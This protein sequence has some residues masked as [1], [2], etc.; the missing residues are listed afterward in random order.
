MSA[1][2]RLSREIQRISDLS[3]AGIYYTQ[4]P[5]LITRGTAMIIGPQDSIYANCPLFFRFDFPDDYP[6]QPPKVLFLTSDGKT[7]FHPN[8]YT[9]G[10]VCLSILGT[11]SGPSWQSTMSFSMILLSLKAL[12]DKNPLRHEPG[13][14]NVSLNHNYAKHY[15]EYVH[16][17]IMKCTLNEFQKKVF[18]HLFEDQTKQL[19]PGLQENIHAIVRERSVANID[20]YY[21]YIPYGMAGRTEWNK[22]ASGLSLLSHCSTITS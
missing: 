12:L 3:N 22:L 21:P 6:F 11:Y 9:D 13:Y 7:R 5:S 18:L 15:S 10:K 1:F 4:D 14:E 20:D 8:L 2:K 19:W 17:R 16:Y